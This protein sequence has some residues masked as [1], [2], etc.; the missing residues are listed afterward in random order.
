[1]SDR[2]TELKKQI[3]DI[4]SRWPYHSVQPY[5]VQELEDLEEELD[6][7]L[8]DSDSHQN[9]PDTEWAGQK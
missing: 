1:M 9:V 3:E 5:L 8:R 7:L 2:I 4:K 6:G